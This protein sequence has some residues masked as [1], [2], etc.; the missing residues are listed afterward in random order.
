MIVDNIQTVALAL[1]NI[2]INEAEK[3]R[4]V[5]D[6]IKARQN[7]SKVSQVAKNY[8]ISTRRVNALVEGY[9]GQAR[10]M[11]DNFEDRTKIEIPTL[12]KRS[13]ESVRETRPPVGEKDE[14]PT[15]P[16]KNVGIPENVL[17]SEYEKAEADRKRFV[18]RLI[19]GFRLSQSKADELFDA[20]EAEMKEVVT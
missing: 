3:A 1:A 5:M 10:A 6:A 16:E 19:K 4:I 13:K 20:V 18:R 12:S 17:K 15:K 9:M 2:Q 14:I 11:V 7:G 8:N